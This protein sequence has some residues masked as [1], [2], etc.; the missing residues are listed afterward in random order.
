MA[1][2]S[3][4]TTSP[5]EPLNL[6]LAGPEWFTLSEDGIGFWLSTED[7][8][9][10]QHSDR[11]TSRLFPLE[12][13]EW[14]TVDVTYDI[15]GGTY[16]LTI[17]G[18]DKKLPPIVSLRKQKNASGVPGSSIDKFS[19]IGDLDDKSNVTYYG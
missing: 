13:F 16:D 15:D 8:V 12:P 17:F 6:A 11:K 7:G 5:S 18:E 1:H 9:L 2:F 10:F 4:M 3:L 19:F 14:Y